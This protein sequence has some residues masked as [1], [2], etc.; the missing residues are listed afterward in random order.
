MS[1]KLLLTGGSPGRAYISVLVLPV[2]RY[3]SLSNLLISFKYEVKIK[4]DFVTFFPLG[5]VF[6]TLNVKDQMSMTRR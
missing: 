4:C 3:N 5:V 1:L 6:I 2:Q